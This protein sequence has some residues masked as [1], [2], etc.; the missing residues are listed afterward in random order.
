MS[1]LAVGCPLPEIS[2]SPTFGKKV[3]ILGGS[4]DPITDGHLKCACEII[5]A[6]NADEVWI[7]PCGTRPDKPS[8]R[9]PYLH[10]LT[11]CHLAVNTSFGSHFP[12]FVCDIEMNEPEALACY[13]LM[14]K[15]QSDYPHHNFSF[16]IGADLVADLKSWDA[17]GVDKAG[18][19]LY[20]HTSF[21]VMQRPGYVLPP[22]L[23]ANFELLTA[24]SG[25]EIVTENVSSSEIRR[26]IGGEKI[27]YGDVE[28]VELQSGRLDMVDGLLTPSVLAHIIRYRLYQND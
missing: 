28:R 18:N 20:E 4:F 19:W 13:H 3:A 9:T 27:N 12:I 6:R 7:V 21:L 11:M 16:V 17:P 2:K 1:A 25:T 22:D 8:L 14:A 24:L 23:P 5:H 26:R 10:R 15:L